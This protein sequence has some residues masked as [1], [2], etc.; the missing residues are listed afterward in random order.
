M[1]SFWEGILAGAMLAFGSVPR[2]LE[3]I[4]AFLGVI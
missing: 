3:H 4:W 1:S 2:F